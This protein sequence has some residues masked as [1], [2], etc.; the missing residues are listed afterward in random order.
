LHGLNAALSGDPIATVGF[1]R[2]PLGCASDPE[3]QDIAAGRWGPGGFHEFLRT[4][5]APGAPF[6]IRLAQRT[7]CELREKAPF[8]GLREMCEWLIAETA[9]DR[10]WALGGELE[11]SIA[12]VQKLLDWMSKIE[13]RGWSHT[14]C[15]RFF[16]DQVLAGRREPEADGTQNRVRVVLQTV[17][18]AKGLEFPVVVLGGLEAQYD[19]P[20]TLFIGP[21]PSGWAVAT[22]TPDPT[23]RV[24]K[25]IHNVRSYQ[26][27]QRR[28]LEKAAEDLRL[29]YVALTRAEDHLFFV[30]DPD[31]PQKGSWMKHLLTCDQEMED[32]P[33]DSSLVVG[34]PRTQEPA[35]S[36]PELPAFQSADVNPPLQ[37]SASGLHSHRIC[38]IQWRL[39]Q[40][41]PP[42]PGFQSEKE[43]TREA[44]A[45]RGTVLH[46][47][48]E[49]KSV[50]P[51]KGAMAWAAA[52]TGLGWPESV[53]KQQGGR[54]SAD[55]S[56][57]AKD[58][59]LAT[60]LGPNSVAEASFQIPIHGVVLNGQIDLLW[61]ESG[62]WVLTDFKSGDLNADPHSLLQHKAQLTAYAW[63]ASR[64]L[65]TPVTRTEIYAT[66]KAQRMSLPELTA[67]DF[68]THEAHLQTLSADLSAPIPALQEKVLRLSQERPC[69]DCRFNGGAC[70]G[71]NP[72]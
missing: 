25:R 60:M 6:S 68:E 49:R 30:G 50:C 16:N 55:L 27:Q 44:A 59:Q 43:A 58:P 35:T 70:P 56:A 72:K 33:L 34:N 8:S 36:L 14:R 51:E 64:I 46:G 67:R 32:W 1:L 24:H 29:F 31:K 37:L 53:I 4:A 62:H 18:S 40:T 71:W 22:K 3:I 5:L 19:P 54:L 26:I 10:A 57:M 45:L 38:P 13:H 63:A 11:K 52:S 20:S 15:L 65:G 42:V 47:L 69:G 39:S 28:L 48:L 2:S 23:A 41:L 7:L 9:A 66:R 12:N 21:G 17:H 61:E